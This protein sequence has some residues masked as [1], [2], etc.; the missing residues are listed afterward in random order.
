MNE[1][2]SLPIWEILPDLIAALSAARPV[3]LSAPPG[4][5][6]TTM[7]PIALHRAGLTQTG[8]V[9]IS[10]PRRLAVRAVARRMAQLLGE[11]VGETVGYRVRFDRC[12]GPKTRILVVTEGILER[13]LIRDPL[14]EGLACVVLDEF[15]ERSVYTDLALAYLREVRQVRPDLGL[16]VMSAT[17]ESKPVLDYLGDGVHVACDLRSYPLRIEH[18]VAQ[19]RRPLPERIRTAI[20]E[21]L[22]SQDDDA[23]DLLV[24]LPGAADIRATGALLA[25]RPIR[26]LQRVVPLYG[27]LS[28]AEQDRALRS[29][30]G[31][32]RV[33]LATNLAE[34]SL[35]VPGVRAVIDSGLAKR[36]VLDPSVGLSRLELGRISRASATQRAG[37]AGRL[38]PGRVI[39]LWGADEHAALPPTDKP[40][41]LRCD[42]APV[43][44]SVLAF[45]PGPVD[46]FE[47]FQAPAA[48]PLQAA[49][50]LLMGLGAV[51]RAGD[52][53]TDK[54][55]SLAN[56]PVHPRLGALLQAAFERGLVEKGALLAALLTERDILLRQQGHAPELPSCDSDLLLR[57]DWFE[58][59]ER[60]RFSAGTAHSLGIDVGAA[61]EVA[62]VRDQLLRF[63]K[64]TWKAG[65]RAGEPSDKNL[66]RLLL[67]AYPDR[68]CRRRSPGDSR[69]VMVGG[70]GIEL[71]AASGVRQAELF[72][73]LDADAGKRGTRSVSRVRMASQVDLDDL[74]AVFPGQSEEQVEA[75]FD[76]NRE[77]VV[78]LRSLRF[79]DLVLQE[80]FGVEVDGEVASRALA[81]AAL[82]RFDQ[83]FAP[84]AA[85]S[86]WLTRLRFAAR[87]LGELDLPDVSDQGLKNLLADLCWGRRSFSELRRIDWSQVLSGRL[88]HAQRQLL[89]KEVPERLRAPSG[90]QV[91]IDYEAAE[92][93]AG[94]PVVA[95]KLQEMFGAA[96]T[97]V[98]A[99]GRVPV[100]LHLLAPNGRPVQITRD[101]KSFWNDVYPQVRKD[102]RGRYPKHPW[103]EDPWRAKPTARTKKKS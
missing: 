78:G 5:G 83:V 56:L 10:Q 55:R 18:R 81:H 45:H 2:A 32:R 74:Q 39:R 33:V 49:L 95:I 59:L 80:Q 99:R 8:R 50:D 37:R 82:E 48:E 25:E 103:P 94:A 85:G 93:P 88:S 75:V 64:K 53:L 38:G 68:V 19:S 3:V 7:V 54:G 35:T 58:Q 15:H 14:L 66:R 26:G 43:V 69:G 97:P 30:P 6:K 34:T 13:W 4:A 79:S 24:F 62:R 98:V 73:A 51:N 47:F 44:L 61:R 100:L 23:G 36:P 31:V 27:A 57:L 65:S 60:K 52:R 12:E 63:A 91:R 1:D 11:N 67:V 71:S 41:L 70:R 42:L 72:L 20:A 9:L 46:G 86:A 76:A 21:L 28:A 84:D 96:Q 101:L 16:V 77:A 89:D 22:V 17:L 102:L 87:H 40:E 90:N 29:E 92:G